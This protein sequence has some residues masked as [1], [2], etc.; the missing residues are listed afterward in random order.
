MTPADLLAATGRALY[1][2]RWRL[3]LSLDLGISDDTI[4]RWLTG[5]S[6]LTHSHG[7]LGDAER[8]LRAKA[9]EL[10]ALANSIN[11]KR[12]APNARADEGFEQ[13]WRTPRI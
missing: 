3:P 10:L 7:A 1:G 13:A 9:D 6:T 4:R 11:E 5:K 12:K 8:L 2:D